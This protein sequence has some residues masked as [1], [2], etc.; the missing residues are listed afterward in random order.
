MRNALEIKDKTGRI[1]YLSE[2]RWKHIVKEHP[3]L[4]NKIEDIK[5]TILHPIII[6]SSKY[7]VNARFHYKYFKPINKHLLVAV[8]YLNGKGFIFTSFYI[9]RIK[10]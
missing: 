1:I 4:Y 2:E 6:K 9:T 10:K 3:D 7:D 5:E 8:K